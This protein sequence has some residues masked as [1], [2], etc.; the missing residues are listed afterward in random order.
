M[1]VSSVSSNIDLSQTYQTSGSSSRRLERQKDFNQLADALKSGDLSS[2]QQAFSAWQQLFAT[3][4]SNSQTQ[5]QTVQQGT[6]QNP[7]TADISALGQALQSGDL[8]TAQTDFTQLQ[9][10][11]Q[12]LGKGHHHHHYKASASSQDAATAGTSSSSVDLDQLLTAIGVQKSSGTDTSGSV[13][14]LQQ[15]LNTL[16]SIQGSSGTKLDLQG[17]QALVGSKLNISA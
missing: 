2:A 10:D 7:V 6:V 15:W 1:S 12:A 11:I 9:K 16:T 8:T 4:S 14:G 5:T 3:S 13:T 17:L